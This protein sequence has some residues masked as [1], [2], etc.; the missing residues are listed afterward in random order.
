MGQWGCMGRKDRDVSAPYTRTEQWMLTKSDQ[1]L[2][3]H[4]LGTF[5]LQWTSTE[6][7][8]EIMSARNTRATAHAPR[9]QRT[10]TRPLPKSWTP[11]RSLANLQSKIYRR[12]RPAVTVFN[13]TCVSGFC[14]YEHELWEHCGVVVRALDSRV[15]G[16]GFESRSVRTPLDKAFCPQLSLST[17]V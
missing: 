6:N 7:A 11:N 10:S 17:Q 15:R 5:R 9:S 12:R 16:S 13:T 3:A 1:N 4:Q 14:I 8:V 2:V